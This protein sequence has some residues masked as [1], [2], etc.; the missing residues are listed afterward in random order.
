MHPVVILSG[1]KGKLYLLSSLIEILVR[2]A[3]TIGVREETVRYLLRE[4][5]LSQDGKTRW[6]RK[7]ITYYK[8]VTSLISRNILGTAYSVYDASKKIELNTSI[9]ERIV[10]DWITYYQCS[11]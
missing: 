5:K 4:I 2:E 9:Y 8:I 3:L 1:Q 7:L 6:N 10:D 11:G